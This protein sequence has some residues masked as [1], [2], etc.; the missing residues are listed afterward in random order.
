M[1]LGD[2]YIISQT[3]GD[4]NTSSQVLTQ[5]TLGYFNKT[6]LG[7]YFTYL[8]PTYSI[9]GASFNYY[10]KDYNSIS[11]DISNGKIYTLFFSG[12]SI[13]SVSG[14]TGTTRISHDL[15]RLESSANTIYINDPNNLDVDPE[16]NFGTPLISIS[17]Q[18]SAITISNSAYTYSFPTLYKDVG[19]FTNNVF[20]DKDQ[21]MLDTVFYFEE[22]NDLTLGDA[23]YIDTNNNNLPTRLFLEPSATTFYNSNLGS[24]EITGNTPYSGTTVKG[25]FF[26][27]FVPPKKPNLNVSGGRQ[28]I[29]V[30]GVQN[31]LSPVF[32]FA[33]VDD[34]D[35]YYL[36]VNYDTAD[37][38]FS[39]TE[40]YTYTIN[41]QV[42]DAE[43]V[44]TFSTPLK[45]NDDFIY[46]I[47]NTKEILNIFG[48]KQGITTWSDTISASI[49][50]TGQFRFSG[51][52]W[53]NFISTTYDGFYNISGMTIGGTSSTPTTF[54]FTT[55]E[56]PTMVLNTI[57]ATTDGISTVNVEYFG[58]LT[59]RDWANAL[60]S[61]SSWSNLGLY[62]VHDS[63]YT[64]ATE[65][66]SFSFTTESHAMQGVNLT[67]YQL[68]N[69]T[70]LD[71]RIDLREVSE[72]A[73]P[74]TRN[75]VN[76]STT[77][78][79]INRTSGGDGFFDFGLVNGGYFRLVA[80]PPP[81]YSGFE[82]IDIYITINSDL[83]L[84]LIFYIYWGSNYNF[85]LLSNQTFL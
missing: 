11:Y 41:K 10:E 42:G 83:N 60:Y 9:E 19:S 2:F 25:A 67:L 24:V 57:S 46:R 85:A 51:H 74:V 40:I 50:A 72:T 32:N 3:T 59:T 63:P 23:Y 76:F 6:S 81:Q 56:N 64:A 84:D 34:G 45:A 61:A 80:V 7:S 36:Q 54:D 52:T 71:L 30:E 47:G 37:T 1:S 58:T 14:H 73:V 49:V 33:N 13:F 8:Y 70:Q 31:N 68:Y 78:L 15:Y 5:N 21:F 65:D 22:N 48:N 20:N 27:Y 75:Y 17:E 35:F 43:F 26:T 18:V 55:T 4:N 29:A 39:G 12:E 77:G 53:R 16:F 62:I 66:S 38:P 44:R 69:N 82:N 28:L 79:Q